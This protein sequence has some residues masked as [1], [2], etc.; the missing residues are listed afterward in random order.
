MSSFVVSLLTRWVTPCNHTL[1]FSYCEVL[2]WLDLITV[3]L[4]FYFFF[5]FLLGW[6]PFL[7]KHVGNLETNLRG[8]P[9]RFGGRQGSNLVWSWNETIFV[10]TG[11]FKR[12]FSHQPGAAGSRSDDSQ[13]WPLTFVMVFSFPAPLTINRYAVSSGHGWLQR[14]SQHAHTTPII[15]SGLRAFHALKDVF[16]F[17]WEIMGVRS[18]KR[19][20]KTLPGI[21]NRAITMLSQCFLPLFSLTS[22][23]RCNL[24]LR[25]F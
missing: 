21:E 12:R 1:V 8:Q 4:F 11:G 10:Q 22:T 14:Q 13:R 7:S 15:I 17:V 9:A 20:E 16:V 18:V 2:L 25:L 23:A 19:G 5:F 6:C 24:T 3:V